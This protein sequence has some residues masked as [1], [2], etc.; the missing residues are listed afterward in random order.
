MRNVTEVINGTEI[1]RTEAVLTSI[2]SDSAKGLA[3]PL[4]LDN[5]YMHTYFC[6]AASDFATLGS[7]SLLLT[8]LN[9][10]CIFIMGI[11]ILKVS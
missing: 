10:V 4:I 2:L 8:I 11:V 5:K 7:I 3:C 1:N 9:I 6:H